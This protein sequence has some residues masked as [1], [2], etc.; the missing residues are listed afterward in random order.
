M[1]LKTYHFLQKVLSVKLIK[2]NIIQCKNFCWFFLPYYEWIRHEL[3]DVFDES[4]PITEI[5]FFWWKLISLAYRITYKYIR[6]ILQ[7]YSWGMKRSLQ[8]N[9]QQEYNCVSYVLLT[10]IVPLFFWCTI[11]LLYNPD[12][13]FFHLLLLYKAQ[14]FYYLPQKSVLRSVLLH[15]SS[16]SSSFLLCCY[17]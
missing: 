6:Y 16:I 7:I 4:E 3:S 2:L 10:S 9:I 1:L 17:H 12:T 14:W 15:C 5:S 11:T 8:C 13:S